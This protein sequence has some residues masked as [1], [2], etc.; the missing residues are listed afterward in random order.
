MFDK[1]FINYISNLYEN[2]FDENAE[3]S[4]ELLTFVQNNNPHPLRIKVEEFLEQQIRLF[5]SQEF[6]LVADLD[7][8]RIT[9]IY[10]L[11]SLITE[12]IENNYV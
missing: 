8:Y 5:Y 11:D 1:Q 10:E 9:T 7:W 2:I 12:Y 3:N 6:N 4:K